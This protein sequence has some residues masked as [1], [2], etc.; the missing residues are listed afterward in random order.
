VAVDLPVL[1]LQLATIV[2]GAALAR[3][4][5]RRLG[6]PSVVGDLLF[7]L[8]L[9]P[10]ALGLLWPEARAWLFQAEHA[11]VLDV[12]AWIGLA[13]F[14][15]IAGSEMSWRAGETRATLLVGLGGLAVPLLVGAFLA[16]AR[17]G[18]FFPA[19]PG[20]HEVA[21]LAT[22]LAVSALPVLARI[23]QDVD[24]LSHRIGTITIGAGTLD[25]LTG[26]TVLAAAVAGA[27]VGL[28]GH[29]GL[30]VL[31]LAALLLVAVLVD[32]RLMRLVRGRFQPSALFA[33]L[34][35][36]VLVSAW[37][38]HAAGLH[39]VIGPLAVGALLSRHPPLRDYARERLGGITQVLLLPLFF[40]V[41]VAQV[42]LGRIAGAD[43]LLALGLTLVAASAAKL[44]G[45]YLGARAAG[46]TPRASLVAGILL[47]ARGAVGLVVA[48]VG[49][50]AGLLSP[51]GYAILVVVIVLTTVAAPP[52][53]RAYV[54]RLESE[55]AKKATRRA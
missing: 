7:G 40:V 18:W 9:G 8:A 32:R 27:H 51:G 13:L 21:L 41:S 3:G 17:P 34:I 26:W 53:L 46:M 16:L 2:V 25:D 30:N 12:L 10:S 47:N 15:Y 19:R 31:L 28:T 50:D 38:T 42:D 43:G 39:A 5:L 35:A 24:L 1:F 6:Q 11:A 36:A 52:A 48:R 22:V 44:G 54:R 37:A 4:L 49:L 14:M 33:L 20:L 29:L 55:R 45:V 23:L